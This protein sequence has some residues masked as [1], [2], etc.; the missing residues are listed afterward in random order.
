MLN[1][2]LENRFKDET[3]S[4][5]IAKLRSILINL[6]ID[7]EE[8]W[9]AKSEIGTYSLRLVV[10]GTNIGTNGKGSTKNLALASAYGEFFERL[11]NHKLFNIFSYI[12]QP[13]K[14]IISKDEKFLTSKEILSQNCEVINFF[15]K[16][17]KKSSLSLSRKC[18]WFDKYCYN[19]YSILNNN[20][21]YLCLPFKNTFDDKVIYLPRYL[22]DLIYWSNG[23]AAGNSK[24]EALV[25]AISEIIERY[26]HKKVIQE[27]ISL[28]DIPESYLKKFPKIY[29]LWKRLNSMH[30]YS[31]Y[32]KDASLDGKW[33]TAALIVVN[34]KFGTLGVNFGSHPCCEIAIERVFTESTQARQIEEFSKCS[35]LDYSSNA[36]D[37]NT[38]NNSFVNSC[39]VYSVEILKSSGR[40]SLN[41][42]DM[43]YKNN[44]EML[45]VLIEKLNKNNF[46]ILIRD[47]NRFD[48][49]SY[50]VIIPG[51][52]E[53][54]HINEKDLSYA[55]KRD[56]VKK[57][58]LDVS[59]IT[60]SNAKSVI[61]VLNFYS[62]QILQN[63]FASYLPPTYQLKVSCGTSVCGVIYFETM[64]YVMLNKYKE[65]YENF[66]KIYEVVN[67]LD[68]VDDEPLM[69]V[70]AT[71]TYL[72]FMVN[73]CNHINAIKYMKKI[74]SKKICNY[75]DGLFKYKSK[76]LLTQYPIYKNKLLKS[77][78][79]YSFR[80]AKKIINIMI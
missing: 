80:K 57:L 20:K 21:R 66:L 15:L 23:M 16:F 32:L 58:I 69:Q 48:F 33:P 62:N 27:R 65:A 6:N 43:N 73:D 2:L 60:K 51:M 4:N 55:I 74:Y 78:D 42:V 37:E 50:Q 54:Q 70:N 75:I 68:K 9:Y 12:S 25:E 36:I 44:K 46:Q 39:G 26:V 22:T 77:K 45:D 31:V 61:D 1:K 40:F 18:A 53:I 41:K 72:E 7:V 52:S 34:N 35:K 8:H 47:T 13:K 5:T 24:E 59:K 17:N 38:I 30:G 63:T 28:P 56:Y 29:K 3:P 10:K 71:K 11:Q 49:P 64:L 19:S 14:T 67:N 79:F 76:I